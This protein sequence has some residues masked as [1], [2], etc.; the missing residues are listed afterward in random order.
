MVIGIIAALVATAP[1]AGAAYS[2]P[3][4]R[5]PTARMSCAKIGSSAV[6]D[7]KKVAKKSSSIVDRIS[8]WRNTNRSPSSAACHDTSSRDPS[9]DG[10][11]SGTS[12]II[13]SATITNPND[14]A[15]SDVGP[16]D[17]AAPR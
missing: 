6:A 3:Y 16:G 8:G 17:A 5:G 15:L 14:T 9:C 12:R 7:E 4:P 11:R 10:S 13:T 1:I 2:Q